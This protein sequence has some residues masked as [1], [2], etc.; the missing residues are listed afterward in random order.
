[1]L[2]KR[3]KKKLQTHAEHLM[4]APLNKRTKTQPPWKGG[5][6]TVLIGHNDF[7]T[8]WGIPEMWCCY[9]KTFVVF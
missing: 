7:Y 6:K 2:Q 3:K 8:S 1:M 4:M 9:S 5:N